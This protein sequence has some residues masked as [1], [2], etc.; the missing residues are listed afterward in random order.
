[1]RE[2][3]RVNN[4]FFFYFFRAGFDHHDAFG[5]SDD[6]DVQQALAH[7]AVSWVDDELTVDQ[8]HTY[9]ADRPQKWDVRNCE[10]RRSPVYSSDVRIILGV[11]RENEGNDLS[12]TLEAF[13][14]ERPHWTI[15]LPTSQNFALAGPAFALDKSARDTSASVGVFAV[16]NRQREEID[17]LA[18]V[19]VRD[20]G[21]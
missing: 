20:C 2:F 16:I 10:G 12:F 3:N 13:L 18:R 21:R 17:S 14:K 19:G 9:C 11:R 6:H 4:G 15:N 5:S 1:M 7:L 8:S